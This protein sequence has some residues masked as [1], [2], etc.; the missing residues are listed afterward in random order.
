MVGRSITLLT[1]SKKKKTYEG[2]ST[3]FS[4]KILNAL[5][6]YSSMRV[7]VPLLFEQ[8]KKLQ[9]NVYV[10]HKHKTNITQITKHKHINILNA[11]KT[12]TRTANNFFYKQ[13]KVSHKKINYIQETR[14]KNLFSYN[15]S[16]NEKKFSSV[17][18]TQHSNNIHKKNLVFTSK[19]DKKSLYNIENQESKSFIYAAQNETLL[20]TNV[21]QKVQNLVYK[22]E[23][24]TEVRL[25]E[26]ENNIVNLTKVVNK[27]KVLQNSQ[28]SSTDERVTYNVQLQ[29]M[30]E[31]VY[32]LLM[33]KYNNEQRRKGNLYA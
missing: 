11:Q 3:A 16:F 29:E 26:I 17:A 22:S 1:M 19:V 30:S 2:I 27:P 9:H 14:E 5:Q 28:P 7:S 24:I 23:N 33:K 6:R 15:Y 25:Q 32:A 20:N 21:L 10:T 18:H 13:E 4:K 12:D 31:K 8:K